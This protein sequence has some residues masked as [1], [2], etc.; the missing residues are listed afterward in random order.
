MKKIFLLLLILISCGMAAQSL[1]D[2]KFAIVPAKFSFFKEKDKYGLNSL[3]KSFMQKNSFETY[4][5]TD[6][7]PA[8]TVNNKCNSIYVDVLED[9]TLFATKLT[10]VMKDCRNAVLFTSKQGVSKSKDL[11]VAYNQALRNAFSSLSLAKHKYD[12]NEKGEVLA[13]KT[14]EAQ[15]VILSETFEGNAQQTAVTQTTDVLSAQEIENGYQLVDKTPKIVM[16]MYR[17]S[18]PD[19]YM[20]D[21]GTVKGVVRKDNG[22]WLFDYY[23][24]ERL[25]SKPLNIKF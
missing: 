18:Q 16:R 1:N 2:Y 4:L 17:T 11:R 9:N 24:N 21:S 23:E 13:D 15:T 8:E 12:G 14:V 20:A 25:V 10:V 5:D 19:V 7:L 22:Q 3:A 6:L